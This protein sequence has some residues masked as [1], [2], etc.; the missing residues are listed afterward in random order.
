MTHI[1][2]RIDWWQVTMDLQ[3]AG[4]TIKRISDETLIPHSTVMHYRNEGA[5]PRHADGEALLSVWRRYAEAGLKGSP[6]PTRKA[7]LRQRALG[8]V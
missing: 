7:P 8:R 6:P 1:G 3:A 4:I 2:M 5:E